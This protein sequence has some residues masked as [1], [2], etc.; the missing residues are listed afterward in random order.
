[1]G[2]FFFERSFTDDLLYLLAMPAVPLPTETPAHFNTTRRKPPAGSWAGDRIIL[3]GAWVE[4]WPESVEEAESPAT[5]YNEAHCIDKVIFS[6]G[7]SKEEAYPQE[8]VWVLR[9]LSQKIY[10]RS[11]RLP[12]RVYG[13]GEHSLVL[14]GEEGYIQPG[15]RSTPRL[16]NV[17][18][19]RIGW[20]EDP[21]TAM[22]CD[23]ELT[24]GE[25]A[26]D[27]VDIRLLEGADLEGWVDASDDEAGRLQTIWSE[28]G[29]PMWHL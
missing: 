17:L 15:L 11:D 16:I 24:E 9:N 5:L 26:G 22:A 19:A 21:S 6:Y 2:E 20:S 1:M 29:V 27:R 14:P 25:W 10:V 4:E 7:G 13:G 28:D 3:L 23:M 18:L 12:A 8:R